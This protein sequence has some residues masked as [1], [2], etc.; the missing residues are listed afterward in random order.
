VIG[1]TISRILTTYYRGPD[2]PMKLRLWRY[3]RQFSG[4]AP[5][6]IAYGDRAWITIDERDW[7][8]S[9]IFASGSYEPEVWAALAH[10][11]TRDEV[12]WDV[13]AN[14]GSFVLTAAQDHRV[15]SV[16]AFEPDPLTLET[17]KWNLALNGNPAVVYPF[18]LSDTA[19]RKTLIHGPSTNTGMSTLSPTAHTGMTWHV[20]ADEEL[21]TFEVDC[22]TADDLVAQGEALAPT[23]MKVD[24]EGWEYQVLNGAHQLLRSTRLKALAFEAR[25]DAKGGLQDDRLHSLLTR[26]GYSI[27]HIPRP[28]GELRGVEN[29]LAV[30]EGGTC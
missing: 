29:Y 6:T 20:S 12:V 17:L 7:L 15:R 22:R 3:V 27:S 23:L 5:L 28:E 26:F 19:E 16:C 11:A 1:K 13:G 24:V 21:P 2:H 25:S 14:I 8:Q 9:F 4:Y 30:R 10:Y 18:G